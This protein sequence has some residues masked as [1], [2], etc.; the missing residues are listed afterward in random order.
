MTPISSNNLSVNITAKSNIPQ[1][2]V[3][4]KL[5]FIVPNTD[6]INATY[7]GNGTWWAMHTFDDFGT[8]KVSALF[9]GPYNVIVRNGTIAVNKIKTEI[10]GSAI[11]TT[12]NINK[13]L[14]IT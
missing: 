14:V 2:I 11:T 9:D 8:Y 4:G 1:D 5:L 6:P 10:T 7:A 3:G 13:N 12:Y